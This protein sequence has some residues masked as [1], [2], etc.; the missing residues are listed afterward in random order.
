ML[1]EQERTDVASYCQR[2]GRSGLT[3]G[4]SGNISI[5]NRAQGLAAMSPSSMAYD[6]ISAA[7][8]VVMDV[9]QQV[10]EGK[11][12]PS[13]EYA[14]HLN[15]YKHRQD[16]NAVVHTHAPNVTTMAVLAWELPAV[17]YMLAMAGRAT[18]PCVPYSIFGSDE[19]AEA[20]VKYLEGGYAVLL[21]SHGALTAGPNNTYA[22]DLTEHLEFC[23]GIYLKAKSVGEPKILSAQQIDDVVRKFTDY[24]PQKSKSVKIL[25]GSNVV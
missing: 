20:T 19:L 17:H 16:I 2:L 4:S 1:L 15:C 22:Y 5:F 10:V 12:R 21:E 13:S 18:V 14:M 3:P 8:V 25:A 11:H 6:S 24:T 9:E 7:D 23:A